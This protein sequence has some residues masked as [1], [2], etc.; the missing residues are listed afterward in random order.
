MYR[1]LF[2]MH[3]RLNYIFFQVTCF[4]SLKLSLPQFWHCFIFWESV[5]FQHSTALKKQHANEQLLYQEVQS[6]GYGAPTRY[7]DGTAFLRRMS[8]AEA[9]KELDGTSNASNISILPDWKPVPEA[10]FLF[11]WNILF[12]YFYWEASL[13]TYRS[14]KCFY[15]TWNSALPY[16][17]VL[18]AFVLHLFIYVN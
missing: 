4:Q 18:A 3:Q 5:S 15:G 12:T 11:L 10:L 9:E 13:W 6:S 8:V 14:T 1:S 16:P 2:Q 7:L 17:K